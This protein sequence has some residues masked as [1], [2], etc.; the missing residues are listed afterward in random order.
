MVKIGSRFPQKFYDVNHEKTVD[1]TKNST[2]EKKLLSFTTCWGKIKAFR[3][4]FGD[5]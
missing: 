4:N 2:Q 3:V 1:A 5:L